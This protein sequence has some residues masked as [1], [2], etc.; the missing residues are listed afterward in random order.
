MHYLTTRIEFS[1]Y[2]KLWNPDFSEAENKEVYQECHRGHGHNYVLEVT[3]KGATDKDSG[4]VVDLKRLNRLLMTEIFPHVDHKSLNDDV[5]FL[6]G[7][8]TTAE[9][10]SVVFWNIIEKKLSGAKLHKVKLLE[11]ERNVVEYFGEN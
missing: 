1:A 8:I 3:V 11:S 6:E 2:H 5:P 10:L 4:M 7:I 9:N